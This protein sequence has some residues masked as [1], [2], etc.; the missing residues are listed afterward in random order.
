[1][2][3]LLTIVLGVLVAG[4]GVLSAAGAVAARR[5][6]LYR[7]A[8]EHHSTARAA[9]ALLGAP[10]RIRRGA[11]AVTALALG[12][13]GMGLAAWARTAPPALAVALV[14]VLGIPLVLVVAY[15]V[16]RAIGRHWPEGTVR[17]TVPVFERVGRVVAPIEGGTIR[18][19][20][21]SEDESVDELDPVP[22]DDALAVLAGVGGF[23]ERPGREV[24]TPR[25]EIVALPEGASLAEVATLFAEAGY[26][27]IPLYRESLDNIVGM[28]YAFDLLKIDPG[29]ELP[30]RPIATAPA[31]KPCAELLF[32]MQQHR[33]HLALVLDEYGGTAGI[34]TFEDLL[35][36]LVGEIFDEYEVTTSDG[37]GPVILEVTGA[38]PVDEVASRLD[39][40]L[41]D[42]AETIGGLLTHAAGRIPRVG[43]RYLLAGL[44]FDVL[45]ATATHLDRIMIRQTLA[46]AIQLGKGVRA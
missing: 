11:N 8:A 17:R 43:E 29:A 3:G 42:V 19:W 2:M 21:D 18:T 25:T 5:V 15:A 16:P 23:I 37:S 46:G 27:R 32:E 44:E 14:V 13:S 40:Q 9:V 6:D 31:S 41:P 39:V 45:S 12:I 35:E 28:V 20:A 4:V 10:S 26:S 34:V 24:M 33:A 22:D 30:T 36:E 38:T 7:W 1:M